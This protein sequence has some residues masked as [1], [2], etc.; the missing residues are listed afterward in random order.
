MCRNRW[1]I[2]KRHTEIGE[3]QR[4]HHDMEMIYHDKKIECNLSQQKYQNQVSK[5]QFNQ[6]RNPMTAEAVAGP[7]SGVS[8]RLIVRRPGERVDRT[9]RDNEVC[10]VHPNREILGNVDRGRNGDWWAG[11]WYPAFVANRAIRSSRTIRASAYEHQTAIWPGGSG[12]VIY[13]ESLLLVVHRRCNTCIKRDRQTK[14]RP[15]F[16]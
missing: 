4:E 11:E 8:T 1:T 7:I 12:S 13:V 15:P 5:W 10:C 14:V 9:C 2:S 6:H 16:D 3:R